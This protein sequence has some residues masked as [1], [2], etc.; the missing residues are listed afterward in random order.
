[1][2]V[3]GPDSREAAEVLVYVSYVNGANGGCDSRGGAVVTQLPTLDWIPTGNPAGDG[4][5]SWDGHIAD[6]QFSADLNANG[7]WD[8]LLN[9]C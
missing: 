8:V 1:M 7:T 9:A 3:A 4:I 5:P 6:I 2:T